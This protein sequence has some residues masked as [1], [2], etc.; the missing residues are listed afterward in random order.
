MYICVRIH[1]LSLDGFEGEN[2]QK[3]SLLLLISNT[4]AAASTAALQ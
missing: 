2:G 3:S 1:A 4:A